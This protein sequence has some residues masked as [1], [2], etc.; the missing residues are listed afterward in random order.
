MSG[1]SKY[2]PISNILL[3]TSNSPIRV[4]PAF[5]LTLSRGLSSTTN[6]I[7]NNIIYMQHKNSLPVIA[8]YLNQSLV[9]KHETNRQIRMARNGQSIPT[10]SNSAFVQDNRQCIVSIRPIGIGPLVT[11]RFFSSSTAAPLLRSKIV[12]KMTRCWGTPSGQRAMMLSNKSGDNKGK[13]EKVIGNE[14]NLKNSSNPIVGN[15]DTKDKIQ[16][17]MDSTVSSV[18]TNV[19]SAEATIKRAVEELSTGD[20]L[21]VYGIVF[22]I[23]IIAA[24]PRVIRYLRASD[25]DENQYVDPEDP[26]ID[27]AR[28]IREEYLAIVN[29]YK[30]EEDNG[31]KENIEDDK[32]SSGGTL[33]L[34]RIVADL[35]NSSQIQEATTN[36]VT[37]IIQSSQFKT[38]CNILLKELLKDLLDDP[39]TLKQVI[40]LLQNAIA[41]QKI[42][43]AAVQLATDIFGD[44]RVQDELITLVQRLG[45]EKEVQIATQALLIESTHNALNDPEILDHSMEFATDVVGD[46]IVQQ[47]AGEALYN[48][49]SYA[50]RPT[51][52]VCEFNVLK[53][54]CFPTFDFDFVF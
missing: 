4:N 38:A 23:V 48:T 2:S 3:R 11:A 1:K 33:G 30:D 46:D 16:E 18:R 40:H 6:R 20:L 22:L 43:E 37:K 27:L 44:D 50:F 52:S 19:G 17:F 5:P 47:T 53:M 32:K 39:D 34:D 28:M 12:P 36:L 41:D 15:A 25:W 26:V 9:V 54:S 8:P 21:S 14:K 31:N 7:R 42:K 51:L 13:N 24:A 45:T 10:L 49:M 35:L 29:R